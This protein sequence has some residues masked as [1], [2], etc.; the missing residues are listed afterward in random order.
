ME[1]NVN[2]QQKRYVPFIEMNEWFARFKNRNFDVEECRPAVLN[3]P[4]Q[5]ADSK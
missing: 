3:K 2:K 5:N 4:K 1:E